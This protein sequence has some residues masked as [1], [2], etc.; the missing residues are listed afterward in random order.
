MKPAKVQ[1]LLSDVKKVYSIGTTSV[2][3]VYIADMKNVKVDMTN[4]VVE[5][6]FKGLH[7]VLDMT[8]INMIIMNPSGI[9]INGLS[10][11]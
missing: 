9:Q 2:Q 6:D 8:D 10:M 11:P 7:Y 5:Y 4:E 3:R 1:E